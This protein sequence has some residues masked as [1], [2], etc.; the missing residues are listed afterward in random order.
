MY[1]PITFRTSVSG[2]RELP[3]GR[4]E[5]GPD[6]VINALSRGLEVREGSASQ[7]D[8]VKDMF[9]LIELQGMSWVVPEW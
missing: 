1:F 7:T 8:Q 9:V 4:G 6:K 2:S 5:V 3:A